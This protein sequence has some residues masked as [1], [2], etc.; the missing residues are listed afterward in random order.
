MNPGP[1]AGARGGAGPR[2][3]DARG[4]PFVDL[5]AH[6]NGCV[7]HDTLR[8]LAGDDATRK[9]VDR[10]DDAP[11]KTLAECFEYFAIVHRV[12]ADADALR[13]IAR[14][15]AEDFASQ[16]AVHVELRTTPKVSDKLDK[17]GYV[18][19][20]LDGLHEASSA[21]ACSWR[22]VLS[23]NRAE[24]LSAAMETVAVASEFRGQV[25]GVEL[26]GD[27][28][29]AGAWEKLRPAFDDARARGLKVSLHCAEVDAQV[30]SGE[31]LAMINWNPDRV[32]HAV[33]TDEAFEAALLASRIP[34]EICLTSNL[35]TEAAA[36]C[37]KGL[38]DD[39]VFRILWAAES[40]GHPLCVCTDD[41]SLF[42]V[43]G[44]SELALA[45]R[46]FGLS[47]E[48]VAK[49]VRYGA[50]AAFFV[51]EDAGRAQAMRDEVERRL[52]QC[53]RA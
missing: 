33:R 26:S 35:V 12:V 21:D 48:D 15:T 23:V 30:A 2:A 28:T 6:L 34:V 22:L 19:A 50:S 4:W 1:G 14:E 42:R 18:K 49:L 36:R 20:V 3:M 27:P 25:V 40:H 24:D 31:A 41:P 52:D 13:R 47:D 51:D 44:R 37:A 39:H 43:T 8:E 32:G 29:I 5:H 10:L 7:R 17:R 38:V 11:A 46:S 53:L 9:R 16:G 45:Q